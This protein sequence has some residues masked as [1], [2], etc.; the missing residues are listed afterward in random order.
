M[1]L[2]TFDP[3]REISPADVAQRPVEG[4]SATVPLRAF[5]LASANVPTLSHET[6]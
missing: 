3:E 2:E 4:E 1:C 5:A 6:P